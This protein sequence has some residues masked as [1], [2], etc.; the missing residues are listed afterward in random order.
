MISEETKE[1]WRKQLTTIAVAR[2]SGNLTLSEWESGFIDSINTSINMDK[3]L[4]FKQSSALSKIYGR[5][6]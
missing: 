5:I 3:E 4:S 6:E 2:C 1:K